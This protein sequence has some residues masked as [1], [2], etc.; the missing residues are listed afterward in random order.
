MPLNQTYVKPYGTVAMMVSMKKQV[1]PLPG[2]LD[3]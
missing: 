3:F 2:N 1:S